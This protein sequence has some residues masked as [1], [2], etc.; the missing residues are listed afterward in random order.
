MDTSTHKTEVE[1]N[2]IMTISP[3]RQEQGRMREQSK[4][5]SKEETEQSRGKPLRFNIYVFSE[6]VNLLILASELLP[7]YRRAMGRFQCLWLSLVLMPI[8]K[9]Q[10][11]LLEYEMSHVRRQALKNDHAL[12]HVL[13]FM[14][15]SFCHFFRWLPLSL[16]LLQN[17]SDHCLIL[18]CRYSSLGKVLQCGPIYR[19]GQRMSCSFKLTKVDSSF[20]QHNIQIMVK[21]IAGKIRPSFKIVSLIS[22]G[23]FSKPSWTA[24]IKGCSVFE[25][26]KQIIEDDNFQSEDLPETRDCMHISFSVIDALRSRLEMVFLEHEYHMLSSCWLRNRQRFIMTVICT[27]KIG[28]WV[29]W[30]R[31]LVSLRYS[32]EM[33]FRCYS[34][35]IIFWLESLGWDTVL[36]IE[37]RTLRMLSNALPLNICTHLC[38]RIA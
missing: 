4:K 24:W 36:G 37:C 14:E 17:N 27:A 9:G 25:W 20:E 32:G 29:L 35:W 1:K 19:E 31:D 30:L 26:L 13:F 12:L 16:D 22:R 15:I 21:D 18:S 7:S 10:S 28:T 3:H 11:F 33:L 34:P 23:K 5:A 38:I 8:V 6:G 2:V